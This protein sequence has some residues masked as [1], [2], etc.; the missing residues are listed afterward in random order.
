VTALWTLVQL[1]ALVAA[2]C[3]ILELLGE[4][5]HYEEALLFGFWGC[6]NFISMNDWIDAIIVAALFIVA[7][8]EYRH[9]LEE[10]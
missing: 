1:V 10:G 5:S 9:Y 6:L 2:I 3:L 8:I 7:V 4:L